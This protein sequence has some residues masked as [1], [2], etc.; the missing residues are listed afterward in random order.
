MTTTAADEEVKVPTVVVLLLQ[1]VPFSHQQNVTTTAE[2]MIDD[3]M[4]C[5]A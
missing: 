4:R 1:C 5:I 3:A 2:S